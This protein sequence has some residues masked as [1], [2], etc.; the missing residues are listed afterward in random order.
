MRFA[1]IQMK[2]QMID[3]LDKDEA[4]EFT[5]CKVIDETGEPVGTVDGFWMDPSTHRVAFLGVKSS[6][7]S[8]NVHV[9]PARDA[10]LAEKGNLVKLG[11]PM[12]FIKKAPTFSPEGDLA[13]VEKE[14][15]NAYFGRIT[16]LRRTSSIEEY[17]R[18][19]PIILKI[20]AK[21]L[22][23]RIN[24]SAP[25][26]TDAILNAA[27]R[28]FSTRKGLLLIR[29][30]R[31]MP[32][33]SCCERRKKPQFGIAKIRSR[34]AH[35]TNFCVQKSSGRRPPSGTPTKGALYPGG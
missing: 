17:D 2:M 15:V 22:G 16:S 31:W 18:R 35:R 20:Q 3:S 21:I 12:A 1:T 14:E 24:R 28:L 26:K 29:Y 32:H 6:W 30:P 5:G 19:K 11:Y 8:G 4:R 34:G 10:Q 9:V 13:Q 27:T 25:W 33:K 7:L 23:H